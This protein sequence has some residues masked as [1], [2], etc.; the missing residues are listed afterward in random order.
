[1]REAQVT[2]SGT[3]NAT[4]APVSL[5]VQPPSLKALSVFNPITS[6]V[7]T[8]ET[9]A[10]NGLP[11]AGGAVV[12]L[13]S[14]SPSVNPP[15]NVAVAPGNASVSFNVP[16]NAVATTTIVS[17]TATWNGQ[18][19]QA[20]LTLHPQQP[21]ASLTL[22]PTTTT[23]SQG[24]FAT[25]TLASPATQDVQLPINSSNAVVANVDNFVTIPAGTSSGGFNIW[26]TPVTALTA[27]TISVS[28]A[29]V[30][31]SATLTVSPIVPQSTTAANT[32][33]VT[34][35][36][37]DR[38][39]QVL[40]VDATSADPSAALSA[41]VTSSGQLVGTLSNAG[42]GK[43]EGQFSLPVNPQ[44]VTVKDAVSGSA[45]LAVTPK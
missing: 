25:V 37:Y 26:T 41:F 10:L 29:A 21:P 39:K 12:S 18:S 16:T 27:V 13:T 36:E 44:N 15:A 28:G 9:L 34:L 14:T 19:A 7:L 31:K 6:G 2:L 35:A 23:G 8:S 3:L 22:S 32:V 43:Y 20:Q 40:I 1:L 17:L 11:P 33:K 24:S 30:T 4:S 5:T 45:N 38:A 42:G